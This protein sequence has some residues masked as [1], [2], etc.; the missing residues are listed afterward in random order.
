M[1]ISQNQNR[2]KKFIIFSDLDGTL[3]DHRTYSFQAALESLT[4]VKNLNIPLILTSSKTLPEIHEI[5][6]ELDINYPFIIENGSGICFLGESHTELQNYQKI[7]KTYVDFLGEK[8]SKIIDDLTMIRNKHHFN[9][10]GFHEMSV[11]EVMSLTGLGFEKASKSKQ[12]LCSE[13][14]KW[15]DSSEKYK[16]FEKEL[17]LSGYR[18]LKGGRFLHIM[19]N[20][21]KGKA[22][23]KLLKYYQDKWEI[24]KIKTIGIGDSLNDIDMLSVVDV[25]ILVKRPD[26]SYIDIQIDKKVVYAPGIGP[27]GWGKAVKMLITNNRSLSDDDT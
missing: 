2:K 24:N 11:E 5:Q 9:F 14:I 12:R 25:P 6:A 7:D 17:Q 1:N 23:I 18:I 3:L 10:K 21:D 4:I 8:Y 19:G 13:P 22:A 20:T 15:E 27:V 16:T 26:G